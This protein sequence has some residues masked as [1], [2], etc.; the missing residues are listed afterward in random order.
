M[1]QREPQTS[2]VIVQILDTEYRIATQ[3]EYAE[4]QRIAAYV[5]QKMREISALHPGRVPTTTLAVLAA[6]EIAEELLGA[7]NEQ[8]QLARAAQD[9]LE[10][11]NRLVDVRAG[12]PASLLDRT[13]RTTPRHAEERPVRP[14]S[15]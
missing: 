7:R 8:S 9:N 12:I 3:R 4:I 11:L 14:G 15:A 2:G 5:D 10:R 6:M 1:A 13:A